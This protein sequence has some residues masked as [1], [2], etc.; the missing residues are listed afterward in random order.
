MQY[1][2]S[3]QRF[4]RQ[5]KTNPGKQVAGKLFFSAVKDRKSLTR[6][7]KGV[8]ERKPPGAQQG[9]QPW[10][11]TL[12]PHASWKVCL[13]SGRP[14]TMINTANMHVSETARRQIVAHCHTTLLS[15]HTIAGPDG[16][17]SL[18]RTANV[19]CTGSHHGR[20]SALIYIYIYIYIFR[21]QFL[22]NYSGTLS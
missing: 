22:N 5:K 9:E 6:A 8:S 20:K 10:T 17:C 14:V 1:S 12:E 13:V 7:S 21:N 2:R 11:H 16:K 3:V 4:A 19:L 18:Y 15:R